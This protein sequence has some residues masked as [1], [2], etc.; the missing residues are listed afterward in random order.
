MVA[1][2][3]WDLGW[4]AMQELV[5]AALDEETVERAHGVI[6]S[7]DGVRSVHMLRTRRHGHEA[8]ADVHVQVAPRLSVS[9]GHMI[10]QTVEDRL[11]DSVEAITDVTVHIDP[12]DDEEGPPCRGMPLRK[13]ALAQLEANW[14]ALPAAHYIRLHY[15]SGRIDVEL[16]LPME[17][18]ID[19]EAADRMRQELQDAIA[20][21]PKFGRLSILYAQ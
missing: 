13:E 16:V 10:S 6:M 5:D 1:K 4:E 7:V 15:L 11:K 14:P 12:E 3:G 17:A 20:K 21:L 18:Y 19:Q 9:E 2:I 8:A